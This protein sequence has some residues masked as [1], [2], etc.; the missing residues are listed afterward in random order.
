MNTNLNASAKAALCVNYP[1]LCFWTPA[2]AE[3]HNDVNAWESAGRPHVLAATSAVKCEETNSYYVWFDNYICGSKSCILARFDLDTF[4]KAMSEPTAVCI[5]PVGETTEIY[6]EK[7]S[8]PYMFVYPQY[9]TAGIKNRTV[10]WS[11]VIDTENVIT[12]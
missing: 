7:G 9:D 1:V 3:A 8:Y 12:L 2:E 6:D 11:R 5:A 4:D 10:L